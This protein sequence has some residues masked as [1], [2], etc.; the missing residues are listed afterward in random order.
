[1]NRAERRAAGRQQPR[2]SRV[3]QD[4]RTFWNGQPT[5]CRRV[6]VV[7][8]QPPADL[9]HHWLHGTGLVGTTVNAVEVT[10]PA[11]PE[12]MYLYDE[13]GS[14][15]RKVTEGHGGPRYPHRNIPVERIVAAVGSAGSERRA[16]ERAERCKGR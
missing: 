5:P 9:P 16:A 6:R 8:G 12:P 10:Y 7:V 3:Q 14:G 2:G 15:W 1:M 4:I 13:D 11:W